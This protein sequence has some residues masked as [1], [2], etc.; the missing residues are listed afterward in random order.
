MSK[1]TTIKQTTK[2][3]F[4]ET[5]QYY[6]ESSDGKFVKCMY[7]EILNRVLS[8]PNG[9]ILD[10]G[11][12]NGNILKLLEEKTSSNLYGLDLSDNM[13]SEAK[14]RLGKN[15]TL[16]VGDSENLPYKNDKFD[17]IICNASF[18]HYP[19]PDI[20]LKEI[21]RVLKDNGVF[22]LGDPTI[23][24]NLFRNIFNFFLKYS[25]SG[26]Y[27]IYNQKEINHLLN[28]NNF[29]IYKFKMINHR[30]FALNALKIN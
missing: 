19:H 28:K 2:K 26:D 4:D 20:V 12:G 17:V 18:H 6:N 10:L 22:I 16:T 5:A 21:H 11:C 14:K 30:T 24:F 1:L 15:V 27:K 3:H 29:K 9:N 8:V 23:P 7:D 13:I 25:N